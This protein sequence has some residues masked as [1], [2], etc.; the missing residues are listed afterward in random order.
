[1]KKW[2]KIT[3]IAAAVLAA[4]IVIAAIAVSPVA[5]N[6][7]EKHDRELIG[8]SI[9]MERLRMNIFTGRLRIEGLRIGGSEDSTTFFR[10]DSFE[11]RMRLWPLLGNR[12]LVKKIS[13]AGP[14][15]K[16]YQRGNAFSFDDITARFASD[17]TAAATPEKPSKPWEIGIYDISIRNGRVFYKDLALDAEWGMNDINLHIPGVYFSGEKTDVGAV[18][19]FAE[20]GSLSTDVGYNIESSE[21]DIG[22]RLQDFALAGT[23]PYFRQ[24]LDVTAVDGRL[25]ADIRLRG[26]TEHLLSLTTE[27]TASLAGFALRD[28]QQRP[29]AGVDT[30]GVKLAEG[31]LGKMRFVFDR[32]YVSGLSALFEMTPEGNNLAA[33]MKSP[34]AEITASDAAG[35]ATPSPTLRIADLEISNGR[36]T[37]RDLT[38]HRPFEYTVSEIRMRSRD[39]DP[40]KRNSMTVDARM[41][42]TGSAKLRWE[43]T[44]EDMDNQNITLWLTNLDLR[45]FGPYC[46][47]Y[48]AYPL[49]KGNL[50]FRSQNV[51]RDR[52]LDGTNHLDMFEPKVDKKRREIKAEMNIPLKLGL[53]VL[54][55]KKGHVK[56]DLPVRGSLDSPEF[57]YR[58][59]VL[60]AIGNVLLKV[61]TA[62]FSF[63]SGNK[64]NIEYINI[65]PLQYVFTSEQYAS[66]DKIAQALQDKPEMHIVLTQRVNMRRALPRQA[67]G[68]LRMAYAEHL[69]SADT[70]GRQPMSMLE[71]EKI[72]QTDIRTP[73]IMAFA[74]SLLTRQGISPQGLSA[75][76]KAL[77]LYREKAAGQLARMMAAR[78]KALAEY[79]QSTHGA[80]APAFRVQ[81]MDSLALPNYTGRDRYTIA[82]EV[83]GE[84]VEVEAEDDN[85]GAGAETDMSPGDIQAD[86]TGLSAG[87]PAEEAMV[88][89]GAVATSAPAVMETESSG[90]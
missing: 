69:K 54:K 18:L 65:D 37:V 72:Q 16:I 63:L 87:V 8:R 67:A 88:I 29:V 11:M 44:L 26:N 62:P 56:M 32:I 79:M 59:I 76:D 27:G 19:N 68:A 21:F 38:M 85:A 83:D 41:Q 60:K 73:A 78:N 36:V 17:T 51:I 6:Y 15:V 2:I 77:A 42:K 90:E 1:M 5:K 89:G 49:T 70:T 33:L 52:Y 47:H 84:T 57:S 80:T 71:Y 53:Y 24:S 28:R 34:A 74:D 23:L 35:S 22:I 30:L 64:E 58:K 4:L 13:F 40:S 66:L 75:D 20:G 14:D 25:S 45:D 43:G 50:T 46:E 10:L 81:T 82:L 55:D 9:R 39:F 86:S 61:V 3:L 48:T 7:I 12:V 31:D